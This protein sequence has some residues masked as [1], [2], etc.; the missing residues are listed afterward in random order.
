MATEAQKIKIEEIAQKYGLG[1]EVRRQFNSRQKEAYINIKWC[2]NNELGGF[3]NTL[4]DY[5]EEDEEYKYAWNFLHNREEIVKYIKECSQ[6]AIYRE[7]YTGWLA[8]GC[9]Y[10]K[11][12]RFCGNEWIDRV[13]RFRVEVELDVYGY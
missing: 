8:K 3:E 12:F 1:K 10:L 7:G 11:H 13:V 4:L 6:E 9:D 5:S 2:A